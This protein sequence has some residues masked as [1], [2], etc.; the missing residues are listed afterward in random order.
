MHYI[1]HYPVHKIKSHYKC[2]VI[3]S[4][5]N[6]KLY[7]RNLCCKVKVFCNK[8]FQCSYRFFKWTFAHLTHQAT[9]FW[10]YILQETSKTG[11]DKWMGSTHIRHT[12]IV[13]WWIFAVKQRFYNFVHG[14]LVFEHF[15]QS[16]HVYAL[17][18]KDATYLHKNNYYSY[19]GEWQWMTFFI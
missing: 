14:H 6:C 3:L 17:L 12:F 1:F 18:N 4:E 15:Q 2:T 13:F 5:F 9:R 19:F 10:K 16:T 11:K 8:Y 7:S